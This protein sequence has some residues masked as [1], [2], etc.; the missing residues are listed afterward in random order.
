MM[1]HGIKTLLLFFT[2]G[3]LAGCARFPVGSSKAKPQTIAFYNTEDLFDTKNDP[4][5][6]DDAYTPTGDK[7]WTE[8]RYKTKLKNMATVIAGIGGEGGPAVVGLSE[9]EN[10]KTLQDLVNTPPLR[11][12]KMGIIHYDMSTER[13]LDVAFLYQ[14]RHFKPSNTETIKVGLKDKGA[15]GRDILRVRG[16]LR[17]QLVTFYVV[18]WPEAEKTRRGK[19]DDRNQRHVAT[20]LRR[21]INQQ[22]KID[23]DARIIVLGDFNTEPNATVMR[24]VLKAAGRP[25]PYFNEELFNTHYLNFIN[26]L[27]SYT[28]RGDFIM[29]DQ[30]LISK[31]LLNGEAG[32]QYVRGSA[33][34]YSPNNIKFLF[35]KYRDTPIRTYSENLYI[36]GFSDHFPVYIKV[37]N[38]KK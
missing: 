5:T 38:D 29:T 37:R 17:G 22:Q 26:G 20:I 16:A 34:I 2:L 23:K 28:S 21:E 24:D 1:R 3:T 19:A 25:N 15:A 13:G 4:A 31:S 14:P 8:E 6:K 10:K 18:H 9:V 27:G 35:G 11:K 7:A 33:A 32:L 12:L 30:I 36:G